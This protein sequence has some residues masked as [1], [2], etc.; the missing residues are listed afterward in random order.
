MSSVVGTRLLLQLFEL[1]GAGVATCWPSWLSAA[2]RIG[3]GHTPPAV[4]R[5]ASGR[6]DL[7]CCDRPPDPGRRPARARVPEGLVHARLA[8]DR[9]LTDQGLAL[10]G[11]TISWFGAI[12]L[13]VAISGVVLVIS[14]RWWRERR[15]AAILAVAPL[16]W[17]AGFSV[18]VGDRHPRPSAHDGEVPAGARGDR[19]GLLGIAE[20]RSG[21]SGSRPPPS[22]SSSSTRSSVRPA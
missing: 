2:G 3:S 9:H 6:R 4:P 12:G 19:T 5:P 13:T 21:R 10:A 15:T 16:L 18:A 22:C 1:P 17:I 7:D 11:A 8:Q 20:P 14:G